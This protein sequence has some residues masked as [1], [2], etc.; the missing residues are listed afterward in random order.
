MRPLAFATA[1]DP[2]RQDFAPTPLWP[3]WVTLLDA[4]SW[5]EPWHTVVMHTRRRLL[6]RL[7][8][9]HA[10]ALTPRDRKAHQPQATRGAERR[11]VIVRMMT[12]TPI[13]SSTPP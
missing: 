2:R 11:A 1:V 10:A 3:R 4:I 7:G 13:V 6:V 5:H 12:A 9:A 8:A